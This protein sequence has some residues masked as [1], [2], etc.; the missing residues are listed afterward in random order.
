[1]DSPKTLRKGAIKAPAAGAAVPPD[2]LRIAGWV[3]DAA[4]P[5]EEVMVA[6]EGTAVGPLRRGLA[7]PGP[8]AAHP[9]VPGADS[10]GWEVHVDLVGVPEGPLALTLLAR[11]GKR[12]WREL[13]R[14]DVRVEATGPRTDARRRAAFTVV[15]NEPDF[16]PVWLAHYGRYFDAED[17][18]VLDHDSADGSTRGL[19]AQCH[20]FPVHRAASFDHDWLRSTVERFQA[21]LLASYDTVLFAEV[22]ELIVVDPARHAGLGDYIGR[23]RAPAARCTGFEIV[24]HPSEPPVRLDEPILSQRAYW[25]PSKTY[26]KCLI[27]RTPLA[28]TAGFHRELRFPDVRPD[29]DLYL[30]HLHRVDYDRCLARHRAAAAREWNEYDLQAGRGYS[31]IVEPEEFRH[32]FFNVGLDGSDAE[33]IPERLRSL[34]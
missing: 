18:Y 6:V 25:H 23:L 9:D 27:A 17:I 3:L 11:S 22:D 28:W 15:Q 12:R 29:P 34:V 26:S 10:A 31:R 7:S 32:W 13:A 5:V 24:H 14:T 1:M 33:R 19:E 30:L 16:L 8:G 21:L 20:V 2:R 4:G